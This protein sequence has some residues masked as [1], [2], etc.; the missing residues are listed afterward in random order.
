MGSTW[1]RELSTGNNGGLLSDSRPRKTRFALKVIEYQG[2]CA[3]RGAIMTHILSPRP[4]ALALMLAFGVLPAAAEAA[5]YA[6]YKAKQDSPLRLHYGVVQL[7]G[8]C[9]PA[10][11]AAEAAPRLAAAGWTLLTVLSVFDET[12]L[13]ARKADAGQ[14][15]LRF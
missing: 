14:F 6:D 4:F 3:H 8:Q 11:A 9:A 13:E 2:R 7:S 15:F 1:G 10:A 5:C 12:G